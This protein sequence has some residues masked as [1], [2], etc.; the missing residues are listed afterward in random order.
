MRIVTVMH[1][2]NVHLDQRRVCDGWYPAPAPQPNNGG[3]FFIPGLC[4]PSCDFTL[5]SKR[6]PSWDQIRTRQACPGCLAEDAKG[7]SYVPPYGA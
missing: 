5:S 3:R 6:V 1:E 2:I 7:C 4:M